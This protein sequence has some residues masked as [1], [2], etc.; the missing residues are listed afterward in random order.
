MLTNQ[1][2]FNAVNSGSQERFK[3]TTNYEKYINPE[4]T[5][6]FNALMEHKTSR[7]QMSTVAN[8]LKRLEFEEQRARDRIQKA[9]DHL[10]KMNQMREE[11]AVS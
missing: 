1:N 5:E 7:L 4:G 3:R 6:M 10:Y 11:K 9:R 2:S 8:R